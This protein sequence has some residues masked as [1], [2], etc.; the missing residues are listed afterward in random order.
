MCGV[1][2]MGKVNCKCTCTIKL[3]FM[4]AITTHKEV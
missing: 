2:Y 3:V 4:L 1:I